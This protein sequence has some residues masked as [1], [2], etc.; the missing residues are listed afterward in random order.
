MA[1]WRFTVAALYLDSS[2]HFLWSFYRLG[3]H[4]GPPETA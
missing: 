4:L 1:L 2:S 3:N